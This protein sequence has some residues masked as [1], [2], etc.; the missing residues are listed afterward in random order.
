[1]ATSSFVALNS[2]TGQC[3]PHRRPP[4]AYLDR[5]SLFICP[6]RHIK[7]GCP[8]NLQQCLGSTRAVAGRENASLISPPSSSTPST[9]LFV[10]PHA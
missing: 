4:E 3:R 2:F 6:A 1:M 7:V 5:C 9:S 10:A 8:L